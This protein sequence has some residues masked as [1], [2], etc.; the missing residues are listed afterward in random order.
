MWEEEGFSLSLLTHLPFIPWRRRIRYPCEE[1]I[2]NKRE[3]ESC[4]FSR[5]KKRRRWEKIISTFSS[6]GGFPAA[7]VATGDEKTRTKFDIFLEIYISSL[8]KINS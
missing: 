1:K 5:R 8:L 2:G 3:K 4:L 6:R 7:S